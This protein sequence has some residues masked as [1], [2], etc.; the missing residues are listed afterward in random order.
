MEWP[1]RYDVILFACFQL[2]CV[3]HVFLLDHMA[4]SN[5]AFVKRTIHFN[6]S[7]H[8]NSFHFIGDV[9]TGEVDQMQK[10]QLTSTTQ[11]LQDAYNRSLQWCSQ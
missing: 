8:F 10:R 4:A 2:Q 11:Y 5:V 1:P 3:V 6:T 9:D 7:C